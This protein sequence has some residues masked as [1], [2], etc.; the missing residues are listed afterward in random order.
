MNSSSAAPS[1]TFGVIC[2]E[3]GDWILALPFVPALPLWIWCLS[4]SWLKL[5]VQAFP[6]AT[7]INGHTQ[8]LPVVDVLLLSKTTLGQ[9][10]VVLKHCPS[11]LVLST[12]RLRCSGGWVKRFWRLSHAQV[13]GCSNGTWTLH[14]V[15][16]LGYLSP[17]PLSQSIS[18][19]AGSVHRVVDARAGN[20]RPVPCPTSTSASTS[21]TS[22]HS[23]FPLDNPFARF[24][25]PSAFTPS[26]WCLRTLT[27]KEK[28]ALQ[29]YPADIISCFSV[30][31]QRLLLHCAGVPS[32]VLGFLLRF[33]LTASGA[34]GGSFRY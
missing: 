32:R 11:S 19:P 33:M 23:L 18:L 20:G 17:A 3:W 2:S 30:A 5:L 10:N 15:H 25:V 31:K 21:G 29:D 26:G 22:C 12:S 24:T 6:D 13:G 28:L 1:V 16:R 7:F 9:C 14:S 4:P 27:L 8:P 34:G